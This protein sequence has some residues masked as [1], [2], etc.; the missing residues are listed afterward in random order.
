M[1]RTL[2]ALTAAALSLALVAGAPAYADTEAEVR[3]GL[4]MLDV[5]VD[6]VELTEEQVL[7]LK[8]VLNGDGD[9]DSKVDQINKILGR[10]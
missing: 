7:Q 8:N 5:Q 4:A 1:K 10:S 9:D 2:T 3:S 6:D